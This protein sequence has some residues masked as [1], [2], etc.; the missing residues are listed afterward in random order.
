M[1]SNKAFPLRSTIHI[2]HSNNVV[3]VS[4]IDKYVYTETGEDL[5]LIDK[6]SV[7]RG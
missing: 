3:Q 5:L 1:N 7:V 2:P 4:V 6:L